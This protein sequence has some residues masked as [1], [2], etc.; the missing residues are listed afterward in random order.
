MSTTP[1][2]HFSHFYLIPIICGQIFEWY[3]YLFTNIIDIQNPFSENISS[4]ISLSYFSLTNGVASIHYNKVCGLFPS[5]TV[6][7]PK[8]SPLRSCVL[9]C[10]LKDSRAKAAQLLSDYSTRSV[11]GRPGCFSAGG[12]RLVCCHW[13]T[14]PIQGEQRVS[15][16]NDIN[17][18]HPVL[19]SHAIEAKSRWFAL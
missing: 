11:D 12:S 8:V 13:K 17:S 2:K 4:R 18:S 14:R 6:N 15:W 7:W 9:V 19:S 5:P 3:Y 10:R 1:L 16:L